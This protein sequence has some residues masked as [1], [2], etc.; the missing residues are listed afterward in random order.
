MELALWSSVADS[1]WD[2]K[3]YQIQATRLI[4][5]NKPRLLLPCNFAGLAAHPVL[6]LG[7][8]H[9]TTYNLQICH[10]NLK[11]TSIAGSTLY[12]SLYPKDAYGLFRLYAGDYNYSN[13]STHKTSATYRP[14]YYQN[15][16]PTQIIMRGVR[17]D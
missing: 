13:A 1:N 12:E 10:L 7:N 6:T 5:L 2:Y 4:L 9:S 16:V 8:P 17:I 3:A 14:Y 15:Y 11:L